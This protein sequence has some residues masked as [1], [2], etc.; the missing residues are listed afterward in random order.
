MVSGDGYE[1][2][3]HTADR[4]LRIWGASMEELLEAAT[5]GMLALSGVVASGKE[6]MQRPVEMR[7]EDSE[8]LLVSWLEEIL[9][10]LETLQVIPIEFELDAGE[11][12][13][14]GTVTDVHATPPQ[15]PIKAVTYHN[16]DIVRGAHGLEARLVFDV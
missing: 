9:F 16:L 3:E 2:L 15:K 12:W 13:V 4:S 7:A 11:G 6:A 1:E 5:R 14:V 8:G 10:R